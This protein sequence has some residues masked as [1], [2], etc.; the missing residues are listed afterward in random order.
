MIGSPGPLVRFSERAGQWGRA[1]H[2]VRGVPQADAGWTVQPVVRVW[3]GGSVGEGLLL[4]L[5]FCIHGVSG[6]N[7]AHRLPGTCGQRRAA[8]RRVYSRARW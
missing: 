8:Q 1:L 6:Q 2:A 3:P 5:T 4:L 7:T